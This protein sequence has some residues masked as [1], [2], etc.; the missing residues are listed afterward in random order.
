MTAVEPSPVHENAR[1][2]TFAADQP[3]YAPL[4]AAV[5]K[6]GLV[7]TEWEFSAEDLA[8]ILDGGRLRLWLVTHNK[9]LQPVALEVIPPSE[10]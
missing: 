2:V 9:P 3:E 6:D 7:L 1:V 8:K 4:I 5:D 10:T